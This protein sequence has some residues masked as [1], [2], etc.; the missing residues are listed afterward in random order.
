MKKHSVILK[1]WAFL[2]VGLI[3]WGCAQKENKV[4]EENG[5]TEE[6]S[7]V[8]EENALTEAEMKEGWQLLF[9]GKSMEHFRGFRKSEVPSGWQ[10]EEGAITLAGDEAGDIVTRGQYGNFELSI[11]W[12]ISEGGNSGIMY[13]VSEDT[14]YA[15]TYSSG[16]EMQVLDDERHPDA[17]KGVNGNR[18]AGS[19]YDLIPLSTPAVK[20][21][22][23]WNTARLVVKNGKVEHWLNAKKVVE[24]EMGTP[25]WDV[26][27]QQSKFASMPGFG[28]EKEGHLALQDHGN[29][30]WFRN[31][32]IRP[33]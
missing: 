23:E 28:T 8:N 17:K 19:L 7:K 15:H 10:V 24:Y 12:K 26:M 6:E 3:A 29:R 33:L 31:I 25:A 1:L 32:K 16:P 5:L 13:H 21:A 22:G 18:K 30:V 14:A 2:F 27:V 4:N 20:P 9:D 11:D